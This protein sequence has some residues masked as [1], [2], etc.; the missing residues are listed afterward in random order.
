MVHKSKTN[1]LRDN[2]LS[3]AILTI[4]LLMQ[5]GLTVIGWYKNNADRS[6]HHA[7]AI[8]YGEYLHSDDLLETTMENWESEFLQMYVFVVLTTHL[9]QRGSIASKNPDKFNE[10]DK[11]PRLQ[12]NEP[13][14][15]WP[16]KRGGLILLI[17]EQSLGLAFLLM[18]LVSFALHAIAGA[19]AY[20]AQLVEHGSKAI[21]AWQYL[22]TPQ[23]WFE[24]LQNWQ[25]EFLALGCMVIL[26]I[27]LRERYSPES[28]PVACPHHVTP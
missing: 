17:Y 13:G 3:I 9:Y 24:S 5:S 10:V 16:V 4:F 22:G 23:F 25:S 12:R 11:D 19:G 14:V 6:L 2:G 27:F 26:S 8:S 7:A 28:K 15:P 21:S 18:F 20:S 1:R